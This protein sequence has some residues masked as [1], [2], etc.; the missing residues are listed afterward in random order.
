M[1]KLIPIVYLIFGFYFDL[2]AQPEKLD[3]LNNLI[4]IKKGSEL[5]KLYI[6]AGKECLYIDPS[7]TIDYGEKLIALGNELNDHSKDGIANI[8]IGGGYLF[9]GNFEKGKHYTDLGLQI[10]KE[11]KNV[12]DECAGLN[13]LAV[14]H[15]NT[16][17]YKKALQIFNQTLEKAKAAN[18][19]QRVA[20]ITFNIGAICTNQGQLAEG[21]AALKE[22]LV[23]FNELKDR[24]FIARTLI[25]IAVNYNLWGNY[26][27][28]FEFFEYADKQFEQNNDK[29]GRSASLNNIGEVYKNTGKYTEAI[30]FYSQSLDISISI[31]S[32][33]NEAIAYVG[34]AEAY[35]K[36][37]EMSK[38]KTLAQKSL[39][40][41]SSM[42]ML[43][44]VSRSKQ[45]LA[46][47]EFGEGNYSESMSLADESL[48]LAAKAGIPDIQVQSFLLLSKNLAKTGDYK[49]AYLSLQNHIK[50]KDSLLDEQQKKRLAAMQT[51]LDLK[52][53]EREIVILQKGNEIKDLQIKKQRIRNQFLIGGLVF[54]AVF[55]GVVLRLNRQKK[56][57]YHL[58]AEKN[59]RI[60]EQHNEL[61]KA[62]ETRNRFM[63]IIGHD[64]RN[65]I[66][67]F[68]EML[69]QLIDYP[70]LYDEKLQA[71]VLAE[72]RKEA[73][74]TYYLLENLLSWAS[75][76]RKTIVYNPIAINLKQVIDNNVLL[77]S[78]FSENKRVQ[79]IIEG[80][81]DIDVIFDLNMLNLVLRNLISNALK[82]SF[83]GGIVRIKVLDE[84][85]IVRICVVDQG[86]GIDEE[87]IPLLF[88]P[89][90]HYSTFGTASEKGSGLGLILC[91]EF[92][93][94]NGGE[95]NISSKVGEGTSICFT[96]R[97]VLVS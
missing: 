36:L 44:G 9:S 31:K 11:N 81:Y 68:S 47:V 40:I 88:D 14:Y 87:N 3:S 48:S 52:L 23:Y 6:E 38:A 39:D 65:P 30:K 60:Q 59:L 19:K 69:G 37:N 45:V 53:K 77:N 57:A 2:Y 62:N 15:M 49:N 75:T 83:E 21:L 33:F 41:F 90:N 64:L 84:N 86:V 74:S 35:L 73:D 24:K 92:I 25:N 10:A 55:S 71:Q 34:L 97:K 22:A 95:I 94:N 12:D 67:A 80:R 93:K 91:N 13:S 26:D 70:E 61:K 42:K 51:E 58:L 1:R 16:G 5:L 85:S 66:G 76:Q 28:A 96:L 63:S 27:K 54:F 29:N 72:L 89:N 79:L 8:I 32:V 43:E 7:K 82:F 4:R 46:E 18:L 56:K 20:T 50:L 78:R 17:D